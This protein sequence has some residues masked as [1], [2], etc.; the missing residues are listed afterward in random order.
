MSNTMSNEKCSVTILGRS[1]LRYREGARTVF[2]RGDVLNG[3]F[4]YVVYAR[5]ILVWEGS[6]EAISPDERDRVLSNI[7][8]V[9]RGHG[10]AVDLEK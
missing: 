4:D 7:E 5:S 2:V 9:F 6:N 1:G 3:A 8:E 10:L